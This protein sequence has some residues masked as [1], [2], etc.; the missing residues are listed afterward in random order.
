MQSKIKRAVETT[1][2]AE[3][4]TRVEWHLGGKHDMAYMHMADGRILTMTVSKGSGNDEYKQRGWTRQ[5]IRN[6]GRQLRS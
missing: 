2:K 6:A 4:A 1:A 3:G 5:F